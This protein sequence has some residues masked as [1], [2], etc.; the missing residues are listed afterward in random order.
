MPSC[1][2]PG[3]DKTG[4]S[5]HRLPTDDALRSE[6]VK[7]IGDNHHT[8]TRPVVCSAHFADDDFRTVVRGKKH[9]LL[10]LFLILLSF[11]K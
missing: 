6:W 11:K 5:L 8:L 1:C 10:L 9:P 4:I 7:A 3:C 2:V